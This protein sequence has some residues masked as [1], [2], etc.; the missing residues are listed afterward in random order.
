MI[1]LSL[2][3]G[4]PFLRKWSQ[5]SNQRKSLRLPVDSSLWSSLKLEVPTCLSTRSLNRCCFSDWQFVW[6]SLM[7]C[8]CGSCQ[9]QLASSKWPQLTYEPCNLTIVAKITRRTISKTHIHHTPF[10]IYFAG[11]QWSSAPRKSKYR[12]SHFATDEVETFRCICF[13]SKQP[14]RSEGPSVGSQGE[15]ISTYAKR[16]QASKMME[17][18]TRKSRSYNLSECQLLLSLNNTVL[19]SIFPGAPG[20]SDCLRACL[21]VYVK[22]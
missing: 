22:I 20:K 8:H 13:S 17:L 15:P 9:Q 6:R 16:Q 11:F 12:G 1:C 2:L 19:L 10:L 21:A 4:Q 7:V 5:T 3:P 14:T 18:Q